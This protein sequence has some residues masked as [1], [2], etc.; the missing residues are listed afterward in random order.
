MK[1]FCALGKFHLILMKNSFVLHSA[2]K[3]LE[4]QNLIQFFVYNN[5]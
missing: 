1:I 2:S 5:F 3:P 4:N